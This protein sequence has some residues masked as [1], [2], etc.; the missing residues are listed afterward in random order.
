MPIR[1]VLPV[2]NDE[3]APSSLNSAS[4]LSVSD[5]TRRYDGFAMPI[6]FRKDRQQWWP[7]RSVLSYERDTVMHA[8]YYF[9]Y[10]AT[11]SNERRVS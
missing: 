5:S 2:S 9:G 8:M 3:V 6:L 11:R 10:I 4:N 7:T 1:A